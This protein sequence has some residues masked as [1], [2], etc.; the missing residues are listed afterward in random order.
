MA[1][2]TDVRKIERVAL[3]HVDDVEAELRGQVLVEANR[4]FGYTADSFGAAGPLAVALKALDILPLKTEQVEAYKAAKERTSRRNLRGWV[5]FL[6]TVGA[7]LIGSTV[8]FCLH[9]A[10]VAAVAAGQKYSVLV[11]WT[12][13]ASSA[14]DT[15]SVSWFP[16]II[17]LIGATGILAIV[18]N[19]LFATLFDDV[20]LDRTF[21][22]KW[23][24]F[25]LGQDYPRYIPLHILNL[26]NQIKAVKPKCSFHVDELRV[27]MEEHQPIPVLD[28]F[29]WVRLGPEKYYIAVWDEKEFEAKM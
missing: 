6:I 19:A 28:P 4:N 7:F 21:R 20:L 14:P 15:L 11:D 13:N 5:H 22:W 16:I 23:A 29:L 18:G 3:T 9:E 17:T 2:I 27:S 1:T 12:V 25:T 26:A 24:T 10:A 8:A